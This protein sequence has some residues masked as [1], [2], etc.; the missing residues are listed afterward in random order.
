MRSVTIESVESG[1]GVTK[2]RGAQPTA[3]IQCGVTFLQGVFPGA[4]GFAISLQPMPAI[5]S[6]IDL[7]DSAAPPEGII[8]IAV[9]CPITPKRAINSRPMCNRRVMRKWS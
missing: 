8:A 2:A 4:D 3:D 5:E 9:D 7:A 6:R 1:D